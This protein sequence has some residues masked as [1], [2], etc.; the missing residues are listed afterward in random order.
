MKIESI[1][2]RSKRDRD[3]EVKLEQNYRTI[4]I[5]AI[6]AASQDCCKGKRLAERGNG[7]KETY[8]ATASSR[9]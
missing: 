3:T 1:S 7:A 9:L 8:Q 2:F 4:G 6:A 5:G